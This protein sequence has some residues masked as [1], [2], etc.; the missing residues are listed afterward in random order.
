MSTTR[1]ALTRSPGPSR[2]TRRARALLLAVVLPILAVTAACGGGG[3]AAAPAAPP[4]S[5]VPVATAEGSTPARTGTTVARPGADTAVYAD[6][7]AIEPTQVLPA[8]S[9]FGSPL[10]LV[11]VDDTTPG[12]LQVQLPT[13][14]NESTGW[15]RAE[16]VE[17]RQVSVAVHVDIA[18]RRL[19]VTDEGRTILDT[20]VAVGAPDTPTPTGTFFVVDKLVTGN[21]AGSYGPFALGLSAHSEVLTD[22][23]GGDGQVGIHGTNQ[24]DSIG[25]DVS[26]GCV[27][28]P[29]EIVVQLNDL[30]P[31][32]TPVTVS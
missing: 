14:P 22:F 32:G 2:S 12:W 15:I 16:G 7:G 11:V 31:L 27:R 24:P 19:T 28:V 1:S 23:A 26:N 21:D 8:T 5:V 30:L 13:R 17:L 10:A 29:N 18:A 25:N 9:E 20:P 6:A 4:A 3:G